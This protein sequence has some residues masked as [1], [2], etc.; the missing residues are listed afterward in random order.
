MARATR[1]VGVVFSLR[2]IDQGPAPLGSKDENE[3]M[4]PLRLTHRRRKS[5]FQ[6]GKK[7]LKRKCFSEAGVYAH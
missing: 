4:K 3:K 2:P 7:S 5:Q 6:K 1:N